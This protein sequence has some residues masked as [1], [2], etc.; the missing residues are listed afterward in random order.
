[1]HFGHLGA[2]KIEFEVGRSNFEK[3]QF[4]NF[5]RL[6]HLSSYGIP[7]QSKHDDPCQ[8]EAAAEAGPGGVAAA[9]PVFVRS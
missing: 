5:S 3:C 1:M 2:E 4:S 8:T 6:Y 7:E 9:L